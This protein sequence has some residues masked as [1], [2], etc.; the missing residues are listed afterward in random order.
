MRTK[1]FADLPRW[2]TRVDP[3]CVKQFNTK[4]FIKKECVTP[5]ELGDEFKES[6]LKPLFVVYL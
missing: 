6:T 4:K 5:L 3:V 2:M 1:I